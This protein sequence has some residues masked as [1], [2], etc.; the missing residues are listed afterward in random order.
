MLTITGQSHTYANGTRA[1]DA[2]ASA[3]SVLAF[4]RTPI[5]S[6]KQSVTLVVKERPMFAGVDPYNKRIDRNSDDSLSKVEVGE[7]GR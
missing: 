7:Q 6:G 4:V 3:A 2:K 5:R 1:L